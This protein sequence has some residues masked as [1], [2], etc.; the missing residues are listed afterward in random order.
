MRVRRARRGDEPRLAELN[1]V[2]QEMH[3]AIAPRW[4]K[5]ADLNAIASYFVRMLSSED[6]AVFVAQSDDEVIGYA[7]ARVHRLPET[8][9]TYAATVVELDQISVEPA[10]R[11]TG[12]GRQLIGEVKALA[13]EVGADRVQLTVWDFNEHARAVFERS[14]FTTAMRRMLAG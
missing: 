11:G 7:L 9:L 13:Q 3:R 5:P 1:A 10:A 12:A 2:V 4:F 8:E 6:I 14:G